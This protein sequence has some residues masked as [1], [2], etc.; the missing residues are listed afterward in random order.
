SATRLQSALVVAQIALACALTL[1][2]IL[3]ARSFERLLAVDP[4]FNAS[5]VTTIELAIAG[6]AYVDP[7]KTAAFLEQLETRVRALPGVEHA[8]AVT[9]LPLGSGWD[10]VGFHP[11]D[12]AELGAEAPEFD[13]VYTTPDYFATLGIP[14][15]SGR[16]LAA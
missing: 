6:P 13:R 11:K 8:G 7:K 9:P 4:G 5:D 14:L 2:A 10:T 16:L 15:R 3:M 1:G 12:K